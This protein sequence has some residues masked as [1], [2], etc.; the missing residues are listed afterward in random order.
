MTDEHAP[1]TDA[2]ANS[3]RRR[4]RGRVVRIARRVYLVALAAV[5][6]W[7]A[8]THHEEIVE[9]LAGARPPLIAAALTASFGLILL[10]AALWRSG[11]MMLGHPVAMREPVLAT[12]RALPARYVPLGVTY[13]A[14]R[15]ALLRA[16]GVPLA[17][18]AV[19]A[20]TEMALS[21]SVA[22]ASGVCLLGAAGALP[23]GPAWTIAAA[24]AAAVAVT[25]V[26][27][28][29]AVNHLLARRG[30]RF[31]IAWPDYLRVLATAVAYWAWASCTFVLYLRAFPAADELAT[32]EIAG[33]F[34]VAWAVGFITV[35]APQGLGVAELSLVAILAT[36]DTAGVAMAAVF[37]GY[38][39][40][41]MA[42]DVLAASAGE[43]IASRRVRRGSEPTG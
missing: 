34:M 22:L 37:A 29:R 4:A 14:A 15:M 8:S 42:R 41:L 43:I 19:T 32:I 31:A 36:D 16:A 10:N 20:G 7:L 23:G 12:A 6:I 38:R 40:M 27:G 1:V 33:A 11:L 39:V 25:P 35:L 17:P 26:A 28:G 5:V 3:A 13:A 21:A 30:A 18:L 9:L 2:D 24:V